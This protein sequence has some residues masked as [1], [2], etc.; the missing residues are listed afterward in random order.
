ML[1]PPGQ[2]AFL[3]KTSRKKP[4]QYT[5]NPTSSSLKFQPSK[6]RVKG[7]LE[8]LDPIKP[9]VA[10]RLPVEGARVGKLRNALEKVSLTSLLTEDSATWHKK[11]S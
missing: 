9:Q 2:P 11:K 4:L 8:V 3:K 7:G 5:A 6:A 10:S 1:V